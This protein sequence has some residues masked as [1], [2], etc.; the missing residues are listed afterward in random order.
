MEIFPKKKNLYA[1]LE[2]KKPTDNLKTIKTKK[3]N[4]VLKFIKAYNFTITFKIHSFKILSKK[5][6]PI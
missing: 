2:Q 3:K 1:V 5:Y 6:T 4:L